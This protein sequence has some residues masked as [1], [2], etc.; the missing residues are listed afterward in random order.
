MPA[1]TVLGPSADRQGSHRP[2]AGRLGLLSFLLVALIAGAGAGPAAAKLTTVRNLVISPKSG[3]RVRSPF[4]VSLRLGTGYLPGA[5]RVRLNGRDVSRYFRAVRRGR[6]SAHVSPSQ[7]LHYGRNTLV[8]TVV[9]QIG[10]GRRQTIRFTVPRTQPLA[11][12]GPDLRVAVGSVGRLDGSASMNRSFGLRGTNRRQSKLHL[13]WRLVSKP[14]GSRARL[15][16]ALT[17]TR[18]L[19]ALV[20]APGGLAHPMLKPDRLGRYT[21]RLIVSDGRTSRADTATVEATLETSEVPIDTAVN[22][23]ASNGTRMQGI[24]IGYHPA[25]VGYR[26]P[27]TAAAEQFYPLA[28]GD[29][30][31]VVIVD[32]QTLAPIS[33]ASYPA[34][35]GF[36]AQAK[37]ALAGLPSTDLAI[38]TTWPSAQWSINTLPILGPGFVAAQLTQASGGLGAIG[39]HPLNVVDAT[40]SQVMELSTLS[41]IGVNGFPA[42]TDWERIGGGDYGSGSSAGLDGFL[43]LDPAGNYTYLAKAGASFDLGPDNAHTAT[44]TIGGTSYTAPLPS[45]SMGGFAVMVLHAGTLQPYNDSDPSA[46]GSSTPVV[47]STRNSDGS[48]NYGAGGTTYTGQDGF[49]GMSLYL[50]RIQYTQI[51]EPV[52]VLVRSIGAPYPLEGLQPE[53]NYQG[54]YDVTLANAVDRLSFDIASFGGHAEWLIRMAIPGAANVNQSYSAVGRD[55][56]AEGDVTVADTGSGVS[57]GV[58]STELSGRLERNSRSL[59]A[60]V[61]TA[62]S[63]AVPNPLAPIVTSEPVAWPV[64]QTTAEQAAIGCIGEA[65]GLGT[66][67]RFQYWNLETSA[68]DWQGTYTPRITQLTYAEATAQPNC[69]S[70]SGPAMT[71]AAFTAVR[72]ELAQEFTWMGNLESYV[73]NLSAPFGYNG[74]LPAF[75]GVDSVTEAVKGAL[76]IPAGVGSIDG[77]SLFNNIFGALSAIVGGAGFGPAGAVVGVGSYAFGLWDSLSGD[78]NGSAAPVFAQRNTIDSAGAKIGDQVAA[79]LQAVAQGSQ[80]MTDAIAS[81]YGRLKTV[82]TYENCVPDPNCPVGWELSQANVRETQQAFTLSARRAAWGG[83]LPAAWG[84]VL[85]TN[86]NPNN[87]NGSFNGPQETVQSIYCVTQPFDLT[88]PQFLRF[89]FRSDPASSEGPNTRFMIIA[90]GNFRGASSKFNFPSTKLFTTNGLFSP[91]NPEDI[92]SGPLGMDEYQFL[93]DN[94]TYGASSGPTRENW[95]GC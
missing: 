52:I 38:V 87:Y 81:D 94:Y 67:P 82:G 61:Q 71:H 41:W 21:V 19:L 49:N 50:E 9:P 40:D 30:A 46:P 70:T 55:H 80:A 91:V 72:A 47:F 23:T 39:A 83:L 18:S 95:V 25:Q 59:F 79:R 43:T 28:A 92:N 53:N 32:R 60:P 20:R 22:G 27:N 33:S 89:D 26:Q 75:A 56:T 45:G 63:A 85:Y 44:M 1:P 12:A 2:A 8:V 7:G 10:A 35:L 74:T 13:R 3:A 42:S 66:N 48:A 37:S 54:P 73:H 14:K 84:T 86:S 31:Q 57:P 11:G 24:A 90:N 64:S 77:F 58:P 16:G 76:P 62:N 4:G 88:T 65:V 93:N 51:P 15:S 69:S 6:R 36:I 29:A 17:G 34:G 68:S 5:V 78:D